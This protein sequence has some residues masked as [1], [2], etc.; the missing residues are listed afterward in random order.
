MNY[1]TEFH[2]RQLAGWNKTAISA[3]TN[4]VVTIKGKSSKLG[5]YYIAN[6]SNAFAYLQVFDLA[7]SAAVTLGTTTPD[8][9]YGIP[10][11]AA[12]NIAIDRGIGM[13][14]GIQIAITTTPT[15]SAAPSATCAVTIY[16]DDL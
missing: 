15:G 2:R 8:M 7:T 12:A 14:N 1:Q 11:G 4:S 9:I 13:A 6:P 10:T 3:L 5:G 16:W